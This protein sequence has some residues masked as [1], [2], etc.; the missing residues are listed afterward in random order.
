MSWG[1]S[2]VDS[3]SSE[4][5]CVL[6]MAFPTPGAPQLPRVMVNGGYHDKALQDE[7]TCKI[8]SWKSGWPSKVEASGESLRGLLVIVCYHG[9]T[10]A[11]MWVEMKIVAAVGM[12]GGDMLRSRKVDSGQVT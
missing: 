2:C 3:S 12:G 11:W 10:G 8:T 1:D 5:M 9:D 6:K 4:L 7:V